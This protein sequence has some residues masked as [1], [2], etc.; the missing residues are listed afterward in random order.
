M[1]V[2]S[3]CCLKVSVLVEKN[4]KNKWIIEKLSD[5]MLSKI[6]VNMTQRIRHHMPEFQGD[7]L[8]PLGG[9]RGRTD[10]QTHTQRGYQP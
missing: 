5:R 2:P 7:S 3:L 8:N 4:G 6:V 9:V 10:T 1:A